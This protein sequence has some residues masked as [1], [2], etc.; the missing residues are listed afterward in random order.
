MDI[1]QYDIALEYFFKCLKI[2][3][4]L[5]GEDDPTTGDSLNNIGMIYGKML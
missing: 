5:L 1:M 2:R 3:E 4:S